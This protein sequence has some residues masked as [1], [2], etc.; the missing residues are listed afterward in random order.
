M[1][2]TNRVFP[3]LLP[4]SGFGR[5][6]NIEIPTATAAKEVSIKTWE[7]EYIQKFKELRQY[8]NESDFT[9]IKVVHGRTDL[10]KFIAAMLSYYP[11]W[12]VTLYRLRPLLVHILGL[13]RHESPEELPNLQA[14][15]ISFTPGENVTFFKVR[16]AED[17][18]YWFSETPDDKHLSAYFGVIVEPLK[19]DLK[20]FYIVTIVHYKHWTGPVYFNLIRPF[21]H[22]VVSRMARAGAMS[23]I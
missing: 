7:I 1:A 22:L 6:F 10:R 20:R 5:C 18:A 21:H 23:C 11:W 3:G 2:F 15:E 12:V 14:E 17:E 4:F 16:S 8:F 9:D 13:V 19:N